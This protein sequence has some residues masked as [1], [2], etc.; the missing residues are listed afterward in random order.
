MNQ[1]RKSFRELKK[2]MAAPVEVDK[3][4]YLALQEKMLKR[5]GKLGKEYFFPQ[6][7]KLLVMNFN[8]GNKEKFKHLITTNPHHPNSHK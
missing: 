1:M 5:N 4:K 2:A 7:M 8:N 6:K 3:Q